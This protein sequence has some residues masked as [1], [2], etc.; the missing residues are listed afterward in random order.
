M[1]IIYVSSGPILIAPC[2]NR[3][4]FRH[5]L[6]LLLT[7]FQAKPVMFSG[8]KKL[9]T[10]TPKLTIITLAYEEYARDKPV[11]RTATCLR[12]RC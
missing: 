9:L 4:S 6:Q 11:D 2:L 1:G 7:A 3:S 10:D 8:R 12:A 5:F